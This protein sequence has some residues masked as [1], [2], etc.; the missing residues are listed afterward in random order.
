MADPDG[1]VFSAIR[2]LGDPAPKGGTYVNDFEPGGLNN[3]GDMAFGADVSSGGEEVF[4]RH[5]G[6]ITELGRTGEGAP[7]GGT[8][9]FGFL[10]P[11]GLNDPGD[12]VFNFLLKDFT[13][14]FGVNAGAYRYSHTTETVTPVVVPFVTPVPGGGTFQGVFFQPTINNRGDVVFAG[15]VKTDQGVHNVPDNGEAYIGLGIGIFL[16]DARGR[17]SSVVGPGDA[18]PEGH[19]FDYAVEPWVNDGGDVSFIGHIAGEDSVVAGFPPQAAFI[20]AL[21]SLYVKN[22]GTGEIRT[23]V[24]AGDP[25]PGGGNF[26]QV[27]HDVMNNRGEIA[28]NGDL[29]PAPGRKREHWG[30]S[31]LGRQ[32]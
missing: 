3:H 14:P 28:F 1:Y 24:H 15:I 26:R 2:F 32:D 8:F 9:E 4:L 5:E 6:Q 30:V 25:A 29:T 22:G 19:M 23:I 27:F 20:S 18:A 17:I 10:G 13:P 16:S 11:V 12:M 31:L 7:G 21:G